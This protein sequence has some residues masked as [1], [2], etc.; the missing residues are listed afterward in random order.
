MIKVLPLPD[1]DDDRQKRRDKGTPV[2]YCLTI[3]CDENYHA[4]QVGV[5]GAYGV[6]AS[7]SDTKK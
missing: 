5:Q 1:K 6:M 3:W 7:I 4:L 2:C